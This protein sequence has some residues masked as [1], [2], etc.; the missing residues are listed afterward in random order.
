M[1]KHTALKN[2]EHK[3]IVDRTKKK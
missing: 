3:T 2:R 1:Q